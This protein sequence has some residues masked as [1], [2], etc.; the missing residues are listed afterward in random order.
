MR[1][2]KKESKSWQKSLLFR[3]VGFEKTTLFS[4]SKFIDGY[5]FVFFFLKRKNLSK[6]KEE[7][8][9]ID[10]LNNANKCRNL[11]KERRKKKKKEKKKH[12]NSSESRKLKKQKTTKK[13]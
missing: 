6:R 5:Q 7:E 2:I 3:I 1:G 13:N 8:K 10:F 4:A 12:A 11:L 9:N